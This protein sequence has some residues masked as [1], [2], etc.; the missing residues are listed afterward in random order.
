MPLTRLELDHFTAFTDLKLDLSPGINV[1]VGANG[2][3]K[4]HLMKVCYA[5]CEASRSRTDD[6]FQKLIAI[7]LPSRRNLGRLVRQRSRAECEATIRVWR[8]SVPLE[9][10]FPSSPKPVSMDPSTFADEPD[11]GIGEWGHEPMESVYIPVKEMLSNTRPA[12]DRSTRSGRFTS[13]RSTRRSTRTCWIERI[14][15]HF[16]SR[17]TT[18]GEI[19]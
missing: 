14:F 4:T 11:V 8:G 9:A 5:A 15:H 17:R 12:F 10:S 13:R 6:F 18:G 16:G 7:F 1:L 19:S 2:T 3:G